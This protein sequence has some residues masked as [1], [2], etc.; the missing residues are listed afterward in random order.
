MFVEVP[1]VPRRWLSD[2]APEGDGTAT[3][4]RRVQTARKSFSPPDRAAATPNWSAVNWRLRVSWIAKLATCLDD[5]VDGLGISARGYHRVL[6]VART[7]ADLAGATSV[8]VDHV[9]E[10]ISYRSQAIAG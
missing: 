10:A 9:S 5:A 4:R 8:S 2:S 6:R 1:A 3:V 7:V